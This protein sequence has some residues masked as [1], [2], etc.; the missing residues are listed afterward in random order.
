MHDH[1]GHAAANA[2]RIALR[3]RQD[4]APDRACPQVDDAGEKKRP[5]KTYSGGETDQIGPQRGERKHLPH[6]RQAAMFEH[7]ARTPRSML[8]VLSN[9]GSEGVTRKVS[10]SQL[11]TEPDF[12]TGPGETNIELGIFIVRKTFVVSPH[13]YKRFPVES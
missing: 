1:R 6:L 11:G 8:E 10:Y 12:R 9:E 3:S 7:C 2:R 4:T 5:S 13:R